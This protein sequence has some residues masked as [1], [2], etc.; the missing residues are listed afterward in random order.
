MVNGDWGLGTGYWKLD[1]EFWMHFRP[2]FLYKYIV[3]GGIYEP[4][5]CR[6]AELQ[7]PFTH[8]L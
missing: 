4:Q 3:P 1:A 2:F 5:N 6:T 8:Y 7:N